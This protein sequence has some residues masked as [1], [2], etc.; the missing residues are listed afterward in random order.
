MNRQARA[1]YVKG[2]CKGDGG[3]AGEATAGKAHGRGQVAAGGRLKKV[4]LVEI[5]AAELDGRIG[6]DPDAV[7]A[8]A[9][10][11]AAPALLDPHLLKRLAH[12]ELIVIAT[13]RL[14][15]KQDLEAL[16]G[17]DDGT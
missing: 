3:D 6:H 9:A 16:E 10:H 1:H 2:V 11:K 8:V 5:V 14:D 7:G 12:R 13:D 4:A 17:R 15:L